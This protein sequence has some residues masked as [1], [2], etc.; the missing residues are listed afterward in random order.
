VL[1]GTEAWTD[2]FVSG[3]AEVESGGWIGGGLTA[4]VGEV[5]DVAVLLEH[6]DLLN[7]LDGLDVHL[8]KGGLELLVIG[9][10]VAVDL[11]DHAAGGTL[12]TVRKILLVGLR[13]N[14]NC[15]C[16]SRCGLDGVVVVHVWLGG[17]RSA[18]IRCRFTIP[19]VKI[20]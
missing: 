16:G 18:W 2:K 17:D 5:D 13:W 12:A 7:S 6:V 20:A 10:G 3:C 4:G 1:E 14:W 8:L 19:L 15:G 11:L 9:T